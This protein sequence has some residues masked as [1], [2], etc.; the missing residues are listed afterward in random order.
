[1]S[2]S[3]QSARPAY[4]PRHGRGDRF[5]RVSSSGPSPYLLLGWTTTGRLAASVRLLLA[6]EDGDVPGGTIES[7]SSAGRHQTT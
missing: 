7:T 3:G 1:M 5:P 4:R 2:V 6:P